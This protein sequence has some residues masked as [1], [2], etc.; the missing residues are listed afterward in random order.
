MSITEKIKKLDSLI[1][2]DENTEIGITPTGEKINYGMFLKNPYHI[3]VSIKT[4]SGESGV[5]CDPTVQAGDF[6]VYGEKLQEVTYDIPTDAGY[7]RNFFI[8]SGEV[9]T[10][11][12]GV[13][14]TYKFLSIPMSRR[15][16]FRRLILKLKP[17]HA[18]GVLM[19]TWI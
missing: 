16:E 7:W 3:Q 11:A 6:Q 10:D 17:V 8:V 5:C 9:L 15:L 19:V 1:G 4:Q 13:P 12:F 2:I 14:T 18:W